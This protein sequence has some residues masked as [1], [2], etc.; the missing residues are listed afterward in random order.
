MKNKMVHIYGGDKIA[1]TQTPGS[2]FFVEYKNHKLDIGGA[3][4][5]DGLMKTLEWFGDIRYKEGLEAGNVNDRK[6]I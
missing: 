1:L 4:I 6:P 5:E 3:V 2:H